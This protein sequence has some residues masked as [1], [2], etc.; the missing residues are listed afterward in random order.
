MRKL[1]A[2]VVAAFLT[3]GVVSTQA[4]AGQRCNCQRCQQVRR[5]KHASPFHKLMDL[6]RRKNAWLKKT[7]LG[8]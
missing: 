4:E 3:V 1:L 6:E 5:V 2:L 7:F 8:S